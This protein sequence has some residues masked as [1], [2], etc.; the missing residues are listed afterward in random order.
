[1]WLSGALLAAGQ[2]LPPLATV[3][4]LKHSVFPNGL[5]C[6]ITENGSEKGFADFVL[7]RRSHADSSVV[8]SNENKIVA[9]EEALDSTLIRM[10]SI[11]RSEAMP[12]DQAIIISGDINASSLMTKLRYM[13]LMID[14][15]VPSSLP[16]YNWRGET[17]IVQTCVADTV[18]GLSSILFEWDAP[19][20]PAEYM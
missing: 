1:M 9:T 4:T 17:K 5:S 19:R 6:Y 11:V 13:S 14:G 10:M 3:P 8:Y 15:S 18:S 7:L 20:A 2:E 12:A 16:E